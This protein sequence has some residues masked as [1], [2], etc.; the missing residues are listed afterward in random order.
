MDLARPVVGP[1][2]IHR[3]S[4]QIL[5]RPT[6]MV[7]NWPGKLHERILTALGLEVVACLGERQARLFAQVRNDGLREAGRGVDPGAHRGSAQRQFGHARQSG[8]DT[9]DAQPND[10]GV[11]AELLPQR[12][13][14]GIHEVG[15][16]R[17]DRIR[18]LLGLGLQRSRQD[19]Q[20]RDQPAGHG[21]HGGHV[22][23]GRESIV[24]RL[25]GVDVVVGVDPHSGALRQRGKHLVHVHVAAGARTRLVHVQRE[26]VVVCPLMISSVA[27]VMACA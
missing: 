1:D 14:G 5:I 2:A 19:T 11:S 16:A 27:A 8:F 12:H 18:E 20:R 17:L 26:V 9:F 13:R 6:A 7:R 4:L 10:G 24:A 23:G 21:F 22:D 3:R 25:A 15:S